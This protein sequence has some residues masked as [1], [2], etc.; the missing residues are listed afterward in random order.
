[1]KKKR[2]LSVTINFSNRWLYTFIILGILA[3]VSIGVYALTPGVA[4]NPGHLISDMAPPSPCTQ[5]Q[6]LQFDGTTWKCVAAVDTDTRCDTS[7]TCTKLC[8]GTNCKTNW[9]TGVYQCPSGSKTDC[10][11]RSNICAGQMEFGASQQ[12]CEMYNINCA[13]TIT[14]CN[15]KGYLV[16]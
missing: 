10:S 4:P 1:M 5:N 7:G 8:I 9:N 14:N 15:F 12:T 16:N 3:I 13:K 6:F 11:G 2:G